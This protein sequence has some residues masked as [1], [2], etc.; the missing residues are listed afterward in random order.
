MRHA[1]EVPPAHDGR[2]ARTVLGVQAGAGEPPIAPVSRVATSGLGHQARH[3]RARVHAD[4]TQLAG[5]TGTVCTRGHATSGSGVA[6]GSRGS[7][8]RIT[9]LHCVG[10]DRADYVIILVEAHQCIAGT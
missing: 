1:G 6:Q 8:S 5:P 3:A 10:E 2:H 7:R 9:D 4:V